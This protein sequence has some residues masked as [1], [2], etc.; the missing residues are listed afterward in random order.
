MQQQDVRGC[1]P[2]KKY[3]KVSASQNAL[4]NQETKFKSSPIPQSRC[5]SRKTV[6]KEAVVKEAVVK[7]A[8]VKKAVVKETVEEK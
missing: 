3:V 1:T 6:V 4:L 2:S 5:P 7:K 8:V